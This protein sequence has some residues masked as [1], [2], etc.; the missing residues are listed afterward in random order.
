M[1]DILKQIISVK[2]YVV[3]NNQINKCHPE[4]ETY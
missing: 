4:F 3:I 1:P 2:I